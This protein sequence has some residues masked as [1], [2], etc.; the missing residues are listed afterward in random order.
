MHSTRQVLC[1]AS[2]CLEHR[3]GR[4]VTKQKR[5]VLAPASQE[6]CIRANNGS[7]ENGRI[8][9]ERIQVQMKC[10]DKRP[11]SLAVLRQNSMN[12]LSLQVYCRESNHVP[13]ARFARLF[14]S[15]INRFLPRNHDV[16]QVQRKIVE[17]MPIIHQRY[18][19]WSKIFR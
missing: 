12:H 4:L 2:F 14:E 18:D 9:L 15:K 10:L 1:L 7:L 11:S 6:A 19:H 16:E 13:Q 5:L 8:P 3:L 17:L